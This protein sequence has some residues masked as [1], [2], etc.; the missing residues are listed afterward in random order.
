MT[1][2]VCVIVAPGESVVGV[3]GDASMDSACSMNRSGSSRSKGGGEVE[4]GAGGAP[5]ARS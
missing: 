2:G 3:V 4:G 1:P 5:A